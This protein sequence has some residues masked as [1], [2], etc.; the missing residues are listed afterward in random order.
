VYGWLEEEDE[1]YW[2]EMRLELE[3]VSPTEEAAE[4]LVSLNCFSWSSEVLS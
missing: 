2:L 4:D 1:L 3:G